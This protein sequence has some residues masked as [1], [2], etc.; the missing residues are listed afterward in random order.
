[1]IKSALVVL[2]YKEC[3][4]TINVIK[5]ALNIPEITHI[6]VVDNN[7]QDGSVEELKHFVC[8]KVFLVA[9]AEN[10]GYTKGYN[11]GLD[12]VREQIQ[13]DYIF[14]VNAD[15][16][17]DRELIVSCIKCLQENPEYGL[18]TSRMLD[19]YRKEQ[20]NTWKFPTYMQYLRFNF[21]W[22]RRRHG[23]NVM[24][25]IENCQEKLISVDVIRG[26]FQCFTKVALDVV[27]KY[28]E[29]IFLF[30]FENIVSKKLK[31]A[32]MKVELITNLFYI[33]NHKPGQVNV[34]FRMRKCLKENLYYMKKFE[35]INMFQVFLLWVCGKFGYYEQVIIERFAHL[36]KK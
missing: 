5:T 7:S 9:S 28:D 22:A 33:H 24:N 15:I 12:F 25:E 8:E 3:H 29:N 13:A 23:I 16:L 1:M 30:N 32:N 10:G 6:V 31:M 17:Y 35:Q 34:L 11:K 4:N 21:F 27:K 19:Y 14:V 18:V 2:N 20:W 36:I 26:S